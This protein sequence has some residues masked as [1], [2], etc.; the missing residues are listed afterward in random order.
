MGWPDHPAY[1]AAKG[2][3][4]ALTR[5]LATDYAP[6][7]RVNCIVPGSIQTR[8]WDDVSDEQLARVA[9]RIPIGRLGRPDEV[10]NAILFMSSDAASFITGTALVVDGG[11]TSSVRI[12]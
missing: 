4:V 1:A 3:V 11:E 10:A 2:G 12:D 6:R 9:R 7:I 8:I 5:Q